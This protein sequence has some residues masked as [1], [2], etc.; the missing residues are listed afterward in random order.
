MILLYFDNKYAYWAPVLLESILFHEPDMKVFIQGYNLTEEQEEEI[1]SF[2]NVV[3][4]KNDE[5]KFDIKLMNKIEYRVI[6]WKANQF[7]EAFKKFPEEDLF[8]IMDVDMIL[9]QSLTEL[10]EQMKS[11]DLGAVWVGEKK[12]MG[13]FNAIR[14][15]PIMVEF[16]KS[17]SK[18]MTTGIYTYNKDQPSMAKTFNEFSGKIEFLLLTR[19]YLDH[20]EREES[21]VWS[22]HKSDKLDS[23]HIRVK[24]YS[25]Y[26][27]EQKEKNEIIFRK[28]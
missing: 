8:I 25:N 23:K 9:V 15:T 18:K 5:L 7:L 1:N 17:W 11:H 20:L 19:Q 24:K 27:K 14:K 26:T 13:G 21:Y 3:L 6:C 4:L 12:I 10:K 28:F 22:A 2:K 16:L